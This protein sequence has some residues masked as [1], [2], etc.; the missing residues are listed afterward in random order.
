MALAWTV[1]GSARPVR[2]RLG[3]GKFRGVKA[4][5]IS[6]VRNEIDILECFI[7]YHAEIFDELLVVDHR[8]VDGSLDLLADLHREGLPI[9]VRSVSAP[10]FRQRQLM[11]ELMWEVGATGA[12]L[13]APLDADEFLTTDE[14][15]MRGALE[16]V[17]K[18]APTACAWRT[19]IPMPSD[20]PADENPVTRIVHRRAT[21]PRRKTKVIVPGRI[22]RER[23]YALSSGNH[24]VRFQDTDAE[25]PAVRSRVL[26]IAHYPV[27]S[28]DQL[29]VKLVSWFV[30]C[31]SSVEKPPRL[32]RNHK[33]VADRLG[34]EHIVNDDWLRDMALS[35]MT[36]T[37]P[38]EACDLIAAPLRN[39]PSMHYAPRGQAGVLAVLSD[40]LDEVTAG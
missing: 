2:C 25:Y 15:D 20:N 40:A 21:E 13:V 33:M 19:Y 27:R 29:A 22:A 39:P 37:E 34:R 16:Q 5:L 24:R 23:T 26:H 9:E 14:G 6:V 36:R 10:E 8:S 38:G 12:D 18:Q 4:V 17:S 35:W 7:R 3:G 28:T 1:T 32:N 31:P 30:G 11:T